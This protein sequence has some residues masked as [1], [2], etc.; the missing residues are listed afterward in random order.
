MST[1]TMKSGTHT[2]N[3]RGHESPCRYGRPGARRRQRLEARALSPAQ[4][5][6]ADMVAVFVRIGVLWS[7][8]C[9]L[10]LLAFSG[11]VAPLGRRDAPLAGWS[12][13]AAVLP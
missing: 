5:T 12:I 1:G 3:R 11:V 6:V 4:W 9:C 7:V 8:R 10:D 13:A 2:L